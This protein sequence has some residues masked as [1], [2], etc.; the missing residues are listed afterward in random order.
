[1][2]SYGGHIISRPTNR[3]LCYLG[4]ETRIVVI[5]HH[6]SLANLSTKLS[7]SLLDDRSFSLKY[8][9]S[10][11]DLASLISITTD[12]D[13]DNMIEEYDCILQSS[14][15][16]AAAP[17]GGEGNTGS[18]HSSCLHLF[19]FPSNPDSASSSIGSFLDD[20]KSKTWFIDALN[21]AMGIGI[22]GLSADSASS[23]SRTTPPTHV[24][25]ASAVE[26][27]VVPSL[28]SPSSSFSRVGTPPTSSA[29]MAK[30]S[31]PSPT[32]RCSTPPP[33]SD[34]PPPPPPYPTSL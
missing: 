29:T 8:Q 33:P 24:V 3:S 19:L 23:A 2:C 34:P 16:G 7:R 12:E 17:G 25:S 30:M 32:P 15:T 21:S 26:A 13:L 1:M 9:L 22:N 28:S 18:S 20:S 5:E 31:T 6:P 10:N 4:G 27:L 14:S 11:E